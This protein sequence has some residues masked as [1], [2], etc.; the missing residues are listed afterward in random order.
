MLDYK[1]PTIRK[2]I[3][4]VL[5]K[6][7]KKLEE[8]EEYAKAF[9]DELSEPETRKK[10]SVKKTKKGP[11]PIPVKLDIYEIYQKQGAETL[12]TALNSLELEELQKLVVENGLDPARKVRRWKT[13]TK[14]ISHVVDSVTKKMEKG[15]AFLK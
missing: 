15:A 13:R 8:D 7:A 14:I 9:F 1:N 11:S 4:E 3:A 10:A 5:I 12:E 6:M 2:Q